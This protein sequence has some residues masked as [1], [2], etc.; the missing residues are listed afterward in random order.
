MGSLALFVSVY[1]DDFP[2]VFMEH[3][4]CTKYYSI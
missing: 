1:F 4:P 2:L 3:G